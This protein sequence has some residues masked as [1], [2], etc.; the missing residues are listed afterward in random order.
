MKTFLLAAITAL[1]FLTA[2]AQQKIAYINTDE[3]IGSMPEAIKADAELNE[4]KQGLGQQYQDLSKDFAA[5][6]SA[7]LRDSLKL[8]AS[9][10]KI[11]SDELY[12]MYQRLSNWQEEA[13]QR[14]QQEANTKI[15][16]IREKAMLAI[17]AVAT[18]KGYA[19][20]MDEANLLVKPAGDDLLPFV[21]KKLGIVDKPAPKPMGK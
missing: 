7:Y 3:L 20:V 11:K 1:S 9:I 12:G 5:K 2:S 17:Q 15:G 21:K 18:E 19:F 13:N 8:S 10:K 16:P 4:Y 14:Y 6:D